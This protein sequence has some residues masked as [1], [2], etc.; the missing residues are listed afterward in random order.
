MS[1]AHGLAH[2]INPRIS[3]NIQ[4][5]ILAIFQRYLKLALLIRLLLITLFFCSAS[6]LCAQ[7]SLVK[8]NAASMAL[9]SP[10]LAFEKVKKKQYSW[11]VSASYYLPF[12]K[13]KGFYKPILEEREFKDVHTK[14]FSI[15]AEYRF[16]T[17]RARKEPTKP[18]VAP[19]IRYYQYSSILDFSQDGFDFK[20]DASLA[21]ATAGIQFGVQWIVRKRWS[22]D[23]TMIGMGL[24]GS[25]LE[26]SLE[27]SHPEPNIGLLEDD[28]SEM[29][30]VGGRIQ[31][32]GSNGSYHFSDRFTTV[33][34]RMALYIGLII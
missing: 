2:F 8:F 17:R 20:N 6:C 32:T 4:A 1:S 24:S 13:A 14:G 31:Y 28:F 12:F 25:K 3:V 9:G 10:G 33:G 21:T 23:L 27:T 34:V 26:S 16:Y 29:P 11:Q 22:L 30:L 18:Y 5:P 19:F 15:S 7:I